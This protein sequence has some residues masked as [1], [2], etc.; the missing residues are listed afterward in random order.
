M[1]GH[2]AC[3][4]RRRSVE[5][6]AQQTEMRRTHAPESPSTTAVETDDVSSSTNMSLDSVAS[7]V[8]HSVSLRF[9]TRQVTEMLL[10]QSTT[11]FQRRE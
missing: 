5:T 4:S 11:A 1:T 3:Q 8:L 6:G 2:A 7:P 10:R 9:R